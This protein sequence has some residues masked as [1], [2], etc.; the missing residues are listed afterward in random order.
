[1]A[2]TI[3]GASGFLNAS[4]LANS[5]GIAAAQPSLLDGG[6]SAPDLLEVGR[7][8][9]RN[10]IGLSGNARAVNK[11]FLESS[12]SNFNAL[13]SLGVGTTSSIEGLQK[14]VL[15]LRSSVPQSQLAREIREDDG[16]V[17]ASTNGQTID[18]EA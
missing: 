2:G 17:S 7:R 15:A 1:M 14:G 18:T 11:R 5:R 3:P 6:F 8:I 13:F 9:N 4:T 12:T 16:G 10:K